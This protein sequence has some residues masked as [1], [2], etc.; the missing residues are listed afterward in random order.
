F[1]TL[2]V[3]GYSTWDDDPGHFDGIAYAQIHKDIFDLY[4][5]METQAYPALDRDDL[6]TVDEFRRRIRLYYTR[7]KVNTD[8]GDELLL[9]HL[10]GAMH[11]M[12]HQCGD[13]AWWLRHRMD[14]RFTGGGVN[15]PVTL[16]KMVH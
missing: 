5:E 1:R 4:L 16:P 11:H 6:L 15:N 12:L 8:I 9:L 2:D 3:S 10:N 13:Y 14:L 7:G